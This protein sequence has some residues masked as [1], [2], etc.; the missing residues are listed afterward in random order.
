MANPAPNPQR[1]HTHIPFP[2]R[3][4]L[5]ALTRPSIAVMA[6]LSP[7][8]S[9]STLPPSIRA[10]LMA[11]PS[12]PPPVAPPLSGPPI[13]STDERDWLCLPIRVGLGLIL[14]F[15]IDAQ[16]VD[17]MGLGWDGMGCIDRSLLP[18]GNTAS[19]R[20]VTPTRVR[21]SRG[22]IEANDRKQRTSTPGLLASFC[23]AVAVIPCLFLPI[24]VL[25]RTGRAL[26]RSMPTLAH[27]HPHQLHTIISIYRSILYPH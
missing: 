16:L 8:S 27:Q 23:I 13:R 22:G 14:R 19:R 7:N 9:A 5:Y 12:C 17:R 11:W 24:L 6:P 10:H 20:A 15:E 4:S 3:P 18:V 21:V 1:A 26:F 2:P 25:Y